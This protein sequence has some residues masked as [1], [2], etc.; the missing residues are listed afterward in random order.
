VNEIATK[1][2]VLVVVVSTNDGHWLAACLTVLS[3]S[4]LKPTKILVIENQCT[5]ATHEIIGRAACPI[6]V[7]KTAR[8]LGFAS[9][10]N[11]ALHLGV[12]N[13]YDYV[14]MLNPDTMVHERAIESLVGFLEQCPQYGVAG[15]LQ[16]DYEATGWE[17]L[18]EWSQIVLAEAAGLGSHP[19]TLGNLQIV[20]HYYVQG[21]AMLIRS[22]IVEQVG[23]LDPV[24]RTF[25]E[26]TDFCRRCRLRGLGVAVVIDSKVKHV[27]G[28][29]W[30]QTPVRRRERDI[31]FLRN[32]LIYFLS[33]PHYS[34]LMT[35]QTAI[36]LVRKQIRE[37]Y[38]KLDHVALP[39][40]CYPIVLLSALARVREI[41][42][43]RR[44]NA[45]IASGANRVSPE[46]FA[47]GRD[48]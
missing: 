41:A 31:L 8:R 19:R 21:A 30:K 45:E 6:E 12:Q 16:Y 40:W 34:T 11:I 4:T 26:E 24:Y 36:R 15:S 10:N 43:L 25:Y 1:P 13:G 18:N 27:G 47:I 44:R 29:N 14:F 5:D 35:L 3:E 20:D 33:L 48:Q 22:S 23:M 32:Q 46:L 17:T 39:L 2:R 42:C 7:I 28:G 9:C 37:V 38:R